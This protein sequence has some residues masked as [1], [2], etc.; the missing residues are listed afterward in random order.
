MNLEFNE[1]VNFATDLDKIKPPGFS[2]HYNA[3]NS[4][5]RGIRNYVDAPD[6][7][8]K[9][10][11]GDHVAGQGTI[12]KG[13]IK[14]QA[15]DALG[16]LGWKMDKN[17]IHTHKDHPNTIVAVQNDDENPSREHIHVLTGRKEGTPSNN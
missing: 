14:G 6:I 8:Y 9:H 15:D 1:L 13:M 11:N 2:N 12:G 3:V 10:I 7:E 17:Y 16:V 5:S 4:I